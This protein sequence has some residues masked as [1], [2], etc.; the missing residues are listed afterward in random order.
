MLR[1]TKYKYLEKYLI[2]TER[3]LKIE[4][5]LKDK[6]SDVTVLWETQRV[7]G[8]DY[9][10]DVLCNRD[11]SIHKRA[12]ST[13]A[14]GSFF[15]QTCVNAKYS[16]K[17]NLFGFDFIGLE[18]SESDFSSMV[19]FKCRTCSESRR[20]SVGNVLIMKT[21]KCHNCRTVLVKNKLA[22][23][24]CTYIS[25]QH[26][27]NGLARIT[28]LDLEGSER[29][30][31]EANV[32]RG[33]FSPS[34]SHWNQR[35]FLYVFTSTSSDFSY[36]KIGTANV[37]EKRLKELKLIFDCKITS[38]EFDNRFSANSVESYL[39]KKFS[40]FSLDRNIAESFTRGL[41]KKLKNETRVK[42]GCTEWFYSECESDVI[43]EIE[44]LLQRK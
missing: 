1:Y 12:V 39:H 32:L 20:L 2:S 14:K 26:A 16:D 7:V 22:D 11:G 42:H 44:T 28:Y 10:V 15:C 38:Y 40:S 5:S 43:K 31:S 13:L 21:I 33:S 8:R 3:I 9:E 25:K 23:K 4:T 27:E 30:A 37:P 29:T 17:L 6:Q 24:G 34:E 19:L 35:H 18:K 36:L 41:S